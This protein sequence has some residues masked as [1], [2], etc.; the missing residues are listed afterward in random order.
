[1]KT[2]TK[3]VFLCTDGGGYKKE[4]QLL[5]LHMHGYEASRQGTRYA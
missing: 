5:L 4:L 2:E 1:M 3:T